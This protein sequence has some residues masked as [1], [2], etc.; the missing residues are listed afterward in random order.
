MQISDLL[1]GD[2]IWQ[3]WIG[4]VVFFSCRRLSALQRQQFGRFLQQI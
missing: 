3:G 1:S 2:F 4:W